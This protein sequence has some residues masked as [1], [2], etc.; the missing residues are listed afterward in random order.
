MHFLLK[1]IETT[2][3]TDTTPI[4]NSKQMLNYK[5]NFLSRI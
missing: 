3:N 1:A 5:L 4:L 2:F